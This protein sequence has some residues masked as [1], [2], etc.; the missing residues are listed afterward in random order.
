MVTTDKLSAFGCGKSPTPVVTG[1]VLY[2]GE[3]VSDGLIVFAPNPDRGSDGPLATGRINPDGSF[4]LGGDE[5]KPVAP[6]WYR[7]AVAP[8]SGSLE[9]PTA[10]RPYPGLPTKYRNPTLSGLERE[11]KAGTNSFE[12]DLDDGN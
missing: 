6:G 3:P 11:I 1:R 9:V 8:P 12:F 2:R 10:D 7:V 4:I 5:G